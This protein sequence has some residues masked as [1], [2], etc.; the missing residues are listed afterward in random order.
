L[1]EIFNKK[2][3]RLVSGV[4]DL[5]ITGDFESIEMKYRNARK[6]GG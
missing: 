4:N 1:S 3:L 5:R 6:V 2:F